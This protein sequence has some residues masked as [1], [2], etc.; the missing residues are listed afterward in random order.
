[1]RHFRMIG[2]SKTVELVVTVDGVGGQAAI[3]LAA[4]EEF[5]EEDDQQQAISG[6]SRSGGYLVSS[7]SGIFRRGRPTGHQ[8]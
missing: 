5:F 1:M 7:S 2:G 4:A 6:M 8:R 3:K